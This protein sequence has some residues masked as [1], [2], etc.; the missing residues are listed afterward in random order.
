MRVEG[1]VKWIED[2]NGNRVEA[3]APC[4]YIGTINC[5]LASVKDSLNRE[6]GVTRTGT[7]PNIT[8]TI[9]FNGTGGANR[10]IT[11]VGGSLSGTLK[12]GETIKTY[13]DL[14]PFFFQ[15]SQSG[16]Y[17]QSVNP[18]VIKHIELPD[19]RKYEF[20]LQQLRRA[21]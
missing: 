5:N 21:C 2:R 11:V 20:F 4:T 17:G 6:I 12:S 7:F 10:T 15:S 3:N 14:F 18:E 13:G 19:G 1:R 8:Q 16:Q 9:S